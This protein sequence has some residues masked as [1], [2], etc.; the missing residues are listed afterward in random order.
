MGT[1]FE[2]EPGLDLSGARLLLE[3]QVFLKDRN[4]QIVRSLTLPGC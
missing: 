4:E 3:T 2:G 1:P